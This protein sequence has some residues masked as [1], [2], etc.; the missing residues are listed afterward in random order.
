MMRKGSLWISFQQN[1]METM[2]PT[3]Q[4]GC[5]GLHQGNITTM[6]NQSYLYTVSRGGRCKFTPVSTFS[7]GNDRCELVH[8]PPLYCPDEDQC[9]LVETLA[10]LFSSCFAESWFTKNLFLSCISWVSLYVYANNNGSFISWE[11]VHVGCS[12]FYKRLSWSRSHLG[13]PLSAF[14]SLPPASLS[15]LPLILFFLLPPTPS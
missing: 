2:L 11:S 4:P 7:S 1:K 6:S 10:T 3:F 9:N 8:L 5:T 13:E 15:P 12:P 14:F